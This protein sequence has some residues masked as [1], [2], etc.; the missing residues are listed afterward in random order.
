MSN[1]TCEI[2]S[3]REELIEEVSSKM[4]DGDTYHDISNLFK[5]LGDYNRVRIICALN[6]QEFCVCELSLLLE[7]SQSAISHQ[8]RLLRNKNIVKFRKE[9]KQI[10]YSL[11]S[12]EIISIIKKA[13]LYGF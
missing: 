5:L 13:N 3:I 4:S 6:H 9:N 10:F 8:L 1:S 12:D 7:M 11:Q 2:K